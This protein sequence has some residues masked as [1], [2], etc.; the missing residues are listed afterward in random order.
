MILRVVLNIAALLRLLLLEVAGPLLLVVLERL[1][2]TDEL[3]KVAVG[4]LLNL[5]AAFRGAVTRLI[6]CISFL[7]RLR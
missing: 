2:V 4:S 1:V 5:K 6:G 3:D 7:L